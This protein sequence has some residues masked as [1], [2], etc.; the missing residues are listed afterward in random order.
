MKNPF[1]RKKDSFPKPVEMRSLDEIR[2]EYAE[3]RAKA[4]ELQ[5]QVHIASEDLKFVNSKLRDVN[6]EAANRI[7]FDKE[8]APKETLTP[9]ESSQQ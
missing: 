9:P 5:Y 1:K 2:Q 8:N 6:N 7:K 3:L 4:G